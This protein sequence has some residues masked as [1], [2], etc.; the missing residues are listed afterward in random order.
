MARSFVSSVRNSKVEHPTQKGFSLEKW[1]N[2]FSKIKNPTI[3]ETRLYEAGIW[4]FDRFC[5][6]R[7]LLAENPFSNIES[8]Q[9]IRAY[10]GAINYYT[11]ST[12]AQHKASMEST[13]AFVFPYGS[14]VL[15]EE[16]VTAARY[17]IGAAMNKS[18]NNST[19]P[20]NNLNTNEIYKKIIHNINIGVAYD[21]FEVLWSKCL[22]HSWYVD[23]RPDF[24]ILTP[25]NLRD[26]SIYAAN[27]FR[28]ENI[29]SS[30]TLNVIKI[31]KSLSLST[32]KSL[33]NEYS[34]SKVVTNELGLELL[35]EKILENFQE[36]P[37]E[38]FMQVASEE[39]YFNELLVE[40]LPN[41]LKVRIR[42]LLK[43]WSLFSQIPSFVR[44]EKNIKEEDLTFEEL[45]HYSPVFSK[46][47]L[48]QV[49][50]KAF[51]L[52]DKQ[53][54]EVLKLFTFSG[55]SCEDLWLKPFIPI[56]EKQYTIM[57]AP[58][59]CTSRLRCIEQWM[60][61][62]GLSLD[63]R[64]KAFENFVISSLQ[65]KNRLAN[66]KIV[67][68]SFIFTVDKAK[69]ELDLVC[70]LGNTLLIGEA[71]CSVFPST[72]LELYQYQS[73]LQGA[74][75]Q[76]NRKVGFIKKHLAEFVKQLNFLDVNPESLKVL[77]VIITNITIGSGLNFDEVPVVD[78][79]IL[80][81]FFCEGSLDKFVFAQSGLN[82]VGERISFYFSE[83]EAED[84]L[85]DYLALPPQVEIFLDFLKPD[86]KNLYS[87]SRDKK[88]SGFIDISFDMNSFM[89]LTL[90][91]DQK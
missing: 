30:Q 48:L 59:T 44:P 22:W 17:P 46:P 41:L 64:G 51:N 84:S 53:A 87:F 29:F 12:Y 24:D 36:P 21:L 34:V 67:P 15:I 90:G 74:A 55:K 27:H 32:K 57:F 70:C 5:K 83:K 43:I 35:L 73:T 40:P 65:S 2:E 8:S 66:L 88:I 81:R 82:K 77:P 9:L 62:G 28:R 91:Q 47:K 80:N 7:S 38:F 52:T 26:E 11:E 76:V 3:E 4:F 69:E 14:S 58:L 16:A 25:V 39:I 72:S 23:N 20:T 42:D 10:V 79:L 63:K 60:V 56:N 54:A 86:L 13:Q 31:W 45:F 85:G 6:L 78:T 33:L 75:K 19:N 18:R 89:S 50:C 1:R 49:I 37:L 61:D 71:K 68:K